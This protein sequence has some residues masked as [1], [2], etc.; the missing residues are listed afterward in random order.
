MRPPLALAASVVLAALAL[1][2]C[3]SD[4][5]TTP[6]FFS[7][8][9]DP[10]KGDC[11]PTIAHVPFEVTLPNVFPKGVR[12]VEACT[13]AEPGLGGV[14]ELQIAEFVYESADGGASLTLA[15]ST[16]EVQPKDR[17]VIDVGGLTG[18]VTDRERD[19]GSKVY[20][21]EF[22]KDDRAYTAIAI[23]DAENQITPE[24]IKAVADSVASGT[25]ISP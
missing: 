20:G 8:T 17:Q 3:G 12:L 25:P 13:H 21:I 11:R 14:P 1:A 15:T 4:G 18:Y 22:T 7:P 10:A 9:P 19:D 5:D 23:L 24:D 2:A 6:P 16:I